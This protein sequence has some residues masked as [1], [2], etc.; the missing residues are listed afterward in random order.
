LNIPPEYLS[1]INPTQ[2]TSFPSFG[3]DVFTP[4]FD[5]PTECRSFTFLP[6]DPNPVVPFKLKDHLLSCFFTHYH[7]HY[8]MLLLPDFFE[9]CYP[10]CHHPS[11]LMNAIYA[12]GSIFSR[13][14]IILNGDSNTKMTAATLGK[15]FARMAGKE[16]REIKIEDLNDNDTAS[17]IIASILLCSFE[18]GMD[19]DKNANNSYG[20]LSTIYISFHFDGTCFHRLFL[21]YAAVHLCI[22]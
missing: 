22:N 10:I 8:P 11:Y 7:R 21:S 19:F 18:N 2:S 4:T 12:V 3:F 13:H 20:T 9:L 14:P 1:F 17:Y 5:D 16:L 6:Q 15:R